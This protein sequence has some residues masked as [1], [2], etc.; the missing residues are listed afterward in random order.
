MKIILKTIA[1]LGIFA[2]TACS[3]AETAPEKEQTAPADTISLIQDPLFER[4]LSLKRADP[5]QPSAGVIHPFGSSAEAPLWELAEWA[6]KFYLTENDK[7]TSNG[8]VS[9]S[10]A[11]KRLQFNKS[12]DGLEITME[13][14]TSEE[15]E[16]PR[17]QNEAWPHLLIEQTFPEK[18]LL[19][20]L[21]KLILKFEGKL[22]FAEMKMSEAAF[23]PGLHAAQFQLFLTV[24]N[25]NPNSAYYGDFLWF[26][27]PFYDFRHKV[28][29][30]YAA[31]DV[32]KGDATGKFIYSLGNRD[33]MEGTF[34][35]QEWIQIEKDLYPLIL[36]ALEV[37]KDRGYLTGTFF[38]EFSLSGM[39]LG[40][41]VP[42]TF[43]ASFSFKGL[44]LLAIQE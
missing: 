15:Y 31:Q 41:E 40:W 23:D 1:F 19:K 38:E 6:T 43:D 21:S 18:P 22:N 3:Q 8:T 30:V 34:H 32:G 37:A 35:D 2:T 25:R 28:Q 20:D 16:R 44:E 39:N 10:N 42:G 26:G 12:E 27:I 9:Y 33:Y 11:G 4:G 17:Q 13:V 7:R 14:I 36:N 5:N 29:E 24:Q